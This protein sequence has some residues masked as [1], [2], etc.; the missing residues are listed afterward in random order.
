MDD[1]P[2]DELDACCQ[3][4][5]LEERHKA[6][7]S[8]RLRKFDRSNL[9]NNTVQSVFGS[10]QS[11]KQCGCCSLQAVDY[12]LLAKVK[13]QLRVNTDPSD[14]NEESDDGH[15]S[16]DDDEMWA[17][18]YIYLYIHGYIYRSIDV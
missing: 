12:P 15:E 1:L 4:E 7:V 16:D 9:R 3:K 11:Y 14:I 10:L 13:Q 18:I 5:V 8:K 6:A 17:G 2:F